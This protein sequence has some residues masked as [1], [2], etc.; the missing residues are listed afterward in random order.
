[1]PRCWFWVMLTLL[2]C[3]RF[4]YVDLLCNNCDFLLT[5]MC[6]FTCRA[7]ILSWLDLILIFAVETWY[8]YFIIVASF[9]DSSV[10]YSA[11]SQGN[12]PI[13]LTWNPSRSLTWLF[14]IFC[15]AFMPLKLLCIKTFAFYFYF[16]SRYGAVLENLQSRAD[17]SERIRGCI[18]D[19]APVL[20]IRPDVCVPV[21][22]FLTESYIELK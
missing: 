12:V 15:L 6:S 16:L 13:N 20:E 22:F 5:L 11:S 1:M 7:K 9:W 18:I 14:N 21:L 3:A 2:L 19:S 17:I 10:E 8:L 4:P